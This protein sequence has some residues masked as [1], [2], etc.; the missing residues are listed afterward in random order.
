M[1]S[2]LPNETAP[3][4]VTIGAEIGR[5]IANAHVTP[6]VKNDA[7]LS[8]DLVA[9]AKMVE[10]VID[11]L[12]PLASSK[13]DVPAFQKAVFDFTSALV[14][15]ESAVQRLIAACNPSGETPS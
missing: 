6:S 8:P 9:A 5:L 15:Q 7:T 13:I 3:D 4:A 12:L 2:S 14:T 1:S 11:A 10:A